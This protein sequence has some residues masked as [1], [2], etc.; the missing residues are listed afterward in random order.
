MEEAYNNWKQTNPGLNKEEAWPAQQFPD[1]EFHYFRDCG[2]LVCALAVML[3]H[4]GIEKTADEKLFNPWIL[5]SRLIGCGAF[6]SAADLELSDISK[7]Y[8]LEYEGSVDYSGTA[9]TKIAESGMPCL[10]TVPGVNADR[11]F[12]VL[13]HLLPD[14]AVVFDPMY[15]EKRLST[16]DR[17]CEIRMFRRI[18]NTIT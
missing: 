9:L 5:N 6:N 2:C 10:I 16:Y 1:A 17:I 11:H 4:Y 3:R 7:L 18:A 13:Y 12:L 15:G 8:P 14:D